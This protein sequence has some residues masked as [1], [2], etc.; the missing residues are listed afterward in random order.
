MT[1][2]NKQICEEILAAL[3]PGYYGQIELHLHNGVILYSKMI[4]TKKHNTESN[5]TGAQNGHNR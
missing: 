1:Q 4:T 5:T 2:T 3:P